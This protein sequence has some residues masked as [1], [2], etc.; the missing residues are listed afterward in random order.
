[1]KLCVVALD[2]D[3]AIARERRVEPFVIEAVKETQARGIVVI[4]VNMADW[5]QGRIANLSYP[6]ESV[7]YRRSVHPRFRF[8]SVAVRPLPARQLHKK[9]EFGSA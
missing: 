6:R 9:S 8:R 5:W 3:G 4:L 1:M 2:Y 7:D